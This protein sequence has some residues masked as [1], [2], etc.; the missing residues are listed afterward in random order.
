MGTIT[1]RPAHDPGDRHPHPRRLTPPAPLP[2]IGPALTDAG[3]SIRHLVPRRDLSRRGTRPGEKLPAIGQVGCAGHARINA[4]RRPG[5]TRLD[6]PAG[7]ARALVYGVLS[8]L[9][10][11]EPPSGRMVRLARPAKRQARREVPCYRADRIGRVCENQRRP[12]R[13][14]P[15]SAGRDRPCTGAWGPVRHPVARCARFLPAGEVPPENRN[16]GPKRKY[17]FLPSDR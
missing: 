11:V 15:R 2:R 5:T 3:G 14:Q 17:S 12:T 13:R 4:A 9:H 10:G 1:G 7:T 8:A 6:P 16:R